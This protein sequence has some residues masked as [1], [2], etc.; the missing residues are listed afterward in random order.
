M[1]VIGTFSPVENGYAGSISTL[2]LKAE[3]SILANPRKEGRNTPDFRVMAGAVEVGVAWRRSFEGSQKILLRV[4]LDDPTL[5]EP[6]WGALFEPGADG[7]AR[8]LW[9][10]DWQD[11]RT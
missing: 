4:K 11:E 2:T 9:W 5:P 6:I 8:L 7:I 3:V 1:P 10:R